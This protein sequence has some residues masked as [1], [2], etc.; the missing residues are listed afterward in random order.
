MDWLQLTV[1]LTGH[2]REQNPCLGR[3]DE[4]KKKKGRERMNVSKYG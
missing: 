4:K 3:R 1:W 2:S